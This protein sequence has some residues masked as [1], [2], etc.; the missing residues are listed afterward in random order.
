VLSERSGVAKRA[1]IGAFNS[2][3]R[4][5]A[6]AL[7]LAK[8]SSEDSDLSGLFMIRLFR[9]WLLR[10]DSKSLAPCA[11]AQRPSCPAARSSG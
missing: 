10:L 7:V 11:S 6:T 4:A 5:T 9:S 1:I 2:P 8:D 3:D